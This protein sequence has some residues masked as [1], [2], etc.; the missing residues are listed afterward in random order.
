MCPAK[1]SAGAH[2]GHAGV[3]RA[4]RHLQLEA[5]L[6]LLP[7]GRRAGAQEGAD[8]GRAGVQGAGGR[9]QAGAAAWEWEC[10]PA[11][12][13]ASRRRDPSC[14]CTRHIP[15]GAL[16]G[17]GARVADLHLGG[18]SLLGGGGPHAGGATG[19]PR[20]ARAGNE[21]SQGGRLASHCARALKGGCERW[22]VP[23]SAGSRQKPQEPPI[24]PQLSDRSHPAAAVAR[25][26]AASAAATAP[27][28][29]G[30][31]CC[32]QGLNAHPALS[33]AV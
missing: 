3:H 2:L 16:A 24:A 22:R 17:R 32:C 19:N 20:R 11:A 7:A 6:V 23:K 1:A 4:L 29:D 8:R 26:A 27:R 14:I 33:Q 25:S 28:G 31:R 13:S 12:R 5:V 15:D 21:G 30:R 10:L 18:G 9:R